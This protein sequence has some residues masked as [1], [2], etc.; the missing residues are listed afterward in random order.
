MD[1]NSE[2]DLIM[3]EG[4]GGVDRTHL[5][6]GPRSRPQWLHV[7]IVREVWTG[8]YRDDSVQCTCRLGFYI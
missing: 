7:G 4:S 6:H 2:G 8:D 5:P 3:I 1:P